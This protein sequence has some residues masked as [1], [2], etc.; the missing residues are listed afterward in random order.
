[1]AGTSTHWLLFQGQGASPRLDSRW[2]VL[3]PQIQANAPQGGKMSQHMDS[4][5][6]EAKGAP[7]SCATSML[8]ASC[9]F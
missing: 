2:V 3:M 4:L 7:H 9:Y 1:M 6:G 5:K 8:H